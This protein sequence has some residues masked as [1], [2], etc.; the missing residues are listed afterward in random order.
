[1]EKNKTIKMLYN[2]GQPEN[3]VTEIFIY[4]E[5]ASEKSYDWWRDREGSEVT[6]KEFREQLDKVT[7]TEIHLRINSVGGDVW[8]AN[9]MYSAVMECRQK[10]KKVTSK[11]DG[12]CASAAVQIALAADSREIVDCGIMMIHNPLTF[13]Y[14]YYEIGDLNDV[15]KMLNTCKEAILNSYEKHTGKSRKECS[16]MMDE[17]TYMTADEA[18]E[19]GF[20][21]TIMYE[22]VQPQ[23][24]N[25]IKNM[26]AILNKITAIP[27][28]VKN[29][30]NKKM[31]GA[32]DME[33]KNAEELRT[34]YP[35]L[36]KEIEDSAAKDAF[37][38][39]VEQERN[40]MKDIDEMADKIDGAFLK[41]AKYETVMNAEEAALQA[42]KEGKLI[43]SRALEGI[44]DD[45]SVANKIGAGA[46]T[47]AAL[48]EQ[49]ATKA[50][51]E[52]M[53]KDYVSKTIR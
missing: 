32:E 31:E 15:S 20:A 1:M 26:G 3:D 8:A 40:R 12:I 28:R 5:I 38:K 50:K 48:T 19:K 47:P 41:N 4:D 51:V 42:V 24:A 43:N 27:E 44:E 34:A 37:D 6:A 7:T 29:I 10:G 18:V 52:Q 33:I 30:L 11:I 2:F 13:L 45:A 25:Q 17:T 21:D 14:G 36:V 53:A 22:D 23:V 35:D 9:A 16:Q 49:N 46:P 39:G